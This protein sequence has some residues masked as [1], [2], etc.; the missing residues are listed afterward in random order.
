MKEKKLPDAASLSHQPSSS[1]VPSAMDPCRA[2]PCFLQAVDATIK[3]SCCN[4][5][6]PWSLPITLPVN[7]PI[8]LHRARCP[9]MAVLS[10]HRRCQRPKRP[11]PSS[12][13]SGRAVFKP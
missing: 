11:V 10:H 13:C 3:P 6:L 2:S 12:I 9:A 5:A 7:N 8:Q 1:V 4:Q